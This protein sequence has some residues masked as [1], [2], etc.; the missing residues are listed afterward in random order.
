MCVGGG[1]LLVLVS[2][3]VVDLKWIIIG[4]MLLQKLIYEWRKITQGDCNFHENSMA[5]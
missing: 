3:S 5:V 4:K 2:L 1:C